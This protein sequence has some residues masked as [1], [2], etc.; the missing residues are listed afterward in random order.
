MLSYSDLTAKHLSTKAAEDK[1]TEELSKIDV[2]AYN[3][4]LVPVR[5]NVPLTPSQMSLGTYWFSG[6][7]VVDHIDIIIH[8]YHL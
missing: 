4:P 7:T 2:V 5:N 6:F 1:Y 8:T 3:N